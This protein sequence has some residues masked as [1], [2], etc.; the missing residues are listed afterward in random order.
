MGPSSALT[1]PASSRASQ[2]QLQFFQQRLIDS[3]E[4][5]QQ[6]SARRGGLGGRRGAN[7]GS[8]KQKSIALG[9]D[10]TYTLK[11]DE[12]KGDV[13]EILRNV[14]HYSVRASAMASDDMRSTGNGDAY[15]DRAQQVLHLNNHVFERGSSVY[16]HNQGQRVDGQWT[17]T[18]MNTVEVTLR[19]RDGTKLKVSLSQLRNSRYVLR[20]A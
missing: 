17:V 1:G 6:K 2:A 16:V 4:R 15:F 11:P 19:D 10:A 12:L 14:D 7:G 9:T 8:K 18:A 5:K 20:P 13:D 3:I